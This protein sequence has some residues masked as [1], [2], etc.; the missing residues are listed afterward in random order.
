M[1]G[2]RI[3]QFVLSIDIVD[4]ETFHDLCKLIQSYVVDELKVAYFSVLGESTVNDRLGLQT[5]WSTREELPSYT[6]DKES[7]YATHSAYV[8]GE[9]KPLWIVSASQQPLQTAQDY[10]DMWFGSEDLPHYSTLIQEEVRTS[11]MHPLTIAGRPVG[12]VEFA[13]EKYVEP[14]PASLEETSLLARVI[15]KAYQMYEV[16]RVQRDNTKRAL[17]MLEESRQQESWTRLALPQIFVAYPGTE[18][19]EEETQADHKEVIKIIRDVIREFKDKLQIVFWEDMMEAGSINAQVIGQIT[20]SDFGLPY[21][22]EPLKRGK[23]QD[24]PNVLFEA[25]MMQALTNTLGAQLKG[26]IPVR[27]KASPSIPFDIAA[28]RI[29]V[30]ERTDD[31]TLN[32]AGFTKSLRAR[33]KALIGEE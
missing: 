20:G 16:S 30:V 24:N 17:R 33:V 2:Q 23:Y 26:W 28:E 25:G 18:R 6:I 27:E 32:K 3:Y 10:K 31:G 5:L 11:V 22:S 15:A 7:G 1:F 12:V 29:L 8:F 21:F 13:T 14:T 4:R 9:N 19:L